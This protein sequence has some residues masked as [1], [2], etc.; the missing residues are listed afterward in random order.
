MSTV[1][2]Y[3]QQGIKNTY[4]IKRKKKR[5]RVLPERERKETKQANFLGLSMS[6]CEVGASMLYH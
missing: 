6:L 1:M 4:K 3:R 5:K 2:I